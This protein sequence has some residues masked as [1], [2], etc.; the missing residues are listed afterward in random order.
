[1]SNY[2]CNNT[3]MKKKKKPVRHLSQYI[4]DGGL[5]TDARIGCGMSMDEAASR[6]GCNKCN[7]SRWERGMFQP[8]ERF[9]P[10]LMLLFERTD[11]VKERGGKN[12]NN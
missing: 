3:R 12:G 2:K 7:L 9:I 1:M 5:L 11:F 10:K 4:V 8:E 6:L